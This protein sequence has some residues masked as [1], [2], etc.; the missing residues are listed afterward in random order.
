MNDHYRRRY[1]D[2]YERY[3]RT[4]SRYIGRA[5]NA[6]MTA[7][8]IDQVEHC[9]ACAKPVALI[10]RTRSWGDKPTRI[11]EDLAQARGVPAF[12]V[13]YKDDLD[14]ATNDHRFWVIDLPARNT[15]VPMSPFIYA[16]WLWRLR[17]PHWRNDRCTGAAW[18]L[19]LPRNDEA[20][21][22]ELF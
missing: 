15:E 14:E 13:R 1:P 19:G 12:L 9:F 16:N 8:D 2:S 5:R 7:I 22:L 11:T 6:C 3:H 20:K 10:E 21:Q 17:L 4:L 18:A